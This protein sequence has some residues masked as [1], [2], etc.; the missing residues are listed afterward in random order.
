MNRYFLGFLFLGS[1]LL[2]LVLGD[3]TF[4]AK[5]IQIGVAAIAQSKDVNQLIQ[6]GTQRYQSKDLNGAIEY[7]ETALTAS[8]ESNSPDVE[9]V[10]LLKYLARAYRQV[11]NMDKAI[12]NLEQ[13][14]AYYR[15][16]GNKQLVGRM[17]TEVAQAYSTLGQH[18]RAAAILCG[19]HTVDIVCLEDTALEIARGESDRFGEAAALGSLGNIYRLQGQYTQAIQ[20]LEASLEIAK[21]LDRPTYINIA[22]NSLGNVYA[23]LAK[24]DYSFAEFASQADYQRRSEDF[25]QNASNY[26]RT[27]VKYFTESLELARSQNDDRQSEMRARHQWRRGWRQREN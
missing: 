18:R 13:A 15:E 2:H 3:V 1:L 4:Q 21:Q 8:R 20:S 25:K 12:A 5:Q 24:R 10:T 23:S 16:A 14:I 9:Q 6:Q 19:E 17:L 7:W 26:D 11:G 27:A 22:L